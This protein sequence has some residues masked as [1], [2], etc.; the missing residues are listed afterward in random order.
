M[1]PTVQVN[2]WLQRVHDLY[3]EVEFILQKG[4]LEL[5]K[6]CFLSRFPRNCYSSYR[7]G[8]KISQR[9][10]AVSQAITDANFDVVA[11]QLLR[12]SVDEMPVENDTVGLDSLLEEVWSCLEEIDVSSIGLCGIGRVGK[13][14]LLKKI[15]NEL[16]IRSHNFDVVIWV[17]ASKEVNMEKTQER[18]PIIYGLVKVRNRELQRF[19]RVLRT[20]KF[21]LMIDEIWE[22]IDLVNIGIPPPDHQMSPNRSRDV[23]GLM[24]AQRRIKV[25]CLAREEAINLFQMKVGGEILKSHPDIPKLAKVVMEEYEG[26]PLAL[27]TIGRAMRSTVAGR[28]LRN[29]T[30]Q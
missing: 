8:K 18:L 14:T 29:G 16:L 17:V 12:A 15:N 24:E 22:R 2:G 4:D 25:A 3:R 1:T 19:L 9:L 5:Q 26:L 23:C 20:K 30:M 10:I 7:L 11:Y 28:I 6:K 21:M 27:I 13:T